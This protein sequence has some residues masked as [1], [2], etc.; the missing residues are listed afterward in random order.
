[1]RRLLPLIFVAIPSAALAADPLEVELIGD[2]SYAEQITAIA[3]LKDGTYVKMTFGVSNVGPGDGK[4]AC[5][6]LVIDSSG[7]KKSGEK[8][9]ERE[10]WSYDKK[11]QT[12]EI[13]PCIAK[14]ANKLEMKVELPEGKVTLSLAARAERKR[15][16]DAKV[17]GDFWD[18]DT[19]VKWADATVTLDIGGARR[20]VKGWGY[21]DTSRSRIM[22]GKLAKQW[23]RFRAL[24]GDDPRLVLVRFPQSGSPVGWHDA[25]TGS[26]S[27]LLRAQMR[28]N[29]KQWRA[30]FKGAKGEWR[31]TTNKLLFRDAP[32]EERGAVLGS[33][34]GAVVGNPVTYTFRGVLEERGSKRKI[35]GIV[36]ITL[37]D[38][39]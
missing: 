36:E 25:R 26:K 15:A 17:G 39:K 23:L 30:R 35:P 9:V 28:A 32:I 7:R 10:K 2:E 5:K 8:I 33:M 12:F 11:T 1:M 24:N 22:P 14:N 4:A 20:T 27:K 19:L 37:T 31:V 13:G 21:A 16:L 3:D 6:F 38:E 29:G 18:L 34:I